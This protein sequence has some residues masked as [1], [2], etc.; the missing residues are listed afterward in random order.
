MT[1]YITNPKKLIWFY[2]LISLFFI[3]IWQQAKAHPMPNTIVKLDILDNSIKGESK[4]PLADLESAI[5]Q[6]IKDFKSDFI[7]D[8]FIKH[9]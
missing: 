9:I 2:L 8:Y 3:S 1:K 6:S 4:I 7:Q 5:G